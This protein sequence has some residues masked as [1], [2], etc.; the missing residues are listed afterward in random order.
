MGRYLTP[1][2]IEGSLYK[3]TGY[4]HFFEKQYAYLLDRLDTCD[5][6]TDLIVLQSL[7]DFFEEFSTLVLSTQAQV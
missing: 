1:R 7:V 2:Y 6:E 3:D 4:E 5:N